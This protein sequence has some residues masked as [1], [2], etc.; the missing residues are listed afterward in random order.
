MTALLAVDSI[1]QVR[2]SKSIDLQVLV[3]TFY[4]FANYLAFGFDPIKQINEPSNRNLEIQEQIN[5]P[6][7]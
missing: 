3:N 2:R 5:P 7:K 1:L 4:E 6:F